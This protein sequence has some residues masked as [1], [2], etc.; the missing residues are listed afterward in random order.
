VD[1]VTAIIWVVAF[2]L[3]TVAVTGVAGRFGLSAPFLLVAIGAVASFVPG[4][5][6]VEIEP[7][8]V[9]YA[10]LPPLLF[11]AAIRTSFA[12]IRARGDS[13]FL[14]SVGLVAFT[15][16]TVGMTAWLVIPG[17]TIAAALAFGAVVAPTDAVAV[18]ALT[19]RLRLPRRLVTIL[20]GE[21]LL[22]DAVA[23]VALSASITAIVGQVTAGSVA[24]DLVLA[25]GVGVGGGFVVGWLLSFV[26]QKVQS[27]V[28]DTSLSLVAPYIAFIPV[29]LL[30][31]SGVLAVVIAGLILAH[32]SPAIQSAE[33]R[34]AESINWRTIRFLLENAVFLL[35]GLSLAGIVEEAVQSSPGLWPSVLI[36]GAVLLAVFASR[37]LWVLGT[38]VLYRK[39]PQRLRERGW[40]W[41]NS[42]AVA[43]SGIRGVVTLIAVFLLPEETPYR[44]FLQFLAFVV[45]A[46][47]LAGGLALP[48]V[49]RRL[50]L[51][52]PN[53]MQEQTQRRLLLSEAK[54]AGL[55]RLDE[56]VGDAEEDAVIN[57]L[58]VNGRFLLDDYPDDPEPGTEAPQAAYAR[59]RK[60]MIRAERE[61]VRSARAEGRYEEYAV[62]A[63][64]AAIDAEELALKA[65]ATGAGAPPRRQQN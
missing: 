35:I 31:G 58:R 32:R 50:R 49:I 26:K 24:L 60:D 23:L 42:A 3:V 28:L 11:A 18:T 19:G 45:I 1:S 53:E 30:H 27:A 63:V 48:W 47:S 20:E 7:D 6:T 57:R 10:V 46:A 34:I 36:G 51:P 39:G 38:T 37:V 33:A 61:A 8:L 41:R 2:V 13:I 29:Q 16:V 25:L 21:S 17:I 15:F 40:T 55:A 44:G 9:L 43:V 4:I 59:L 56:T 54:A 5:P 14:L 64:L 65:T 22:N 52:P 62:R 12:E